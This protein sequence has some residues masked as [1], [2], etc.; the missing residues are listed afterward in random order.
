MG[1]KVLYFEEVREGDEA[2]PVVGAIGAELHGRA[3]G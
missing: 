1:K 3:G 2:P